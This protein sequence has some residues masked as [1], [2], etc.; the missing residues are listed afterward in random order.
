MCLLLYERKYVYR[1]TENW[2]SDK[3]RDHWQKSLFATSQQVAKISYP[4]WLPF[5]SHVCKVTGEACIHLKGFKQFRYTF[6]LNRQRLYGL[7]LGVQLLHCFLQFLSFR[8]CWWL[9][10]LLYVCCFRRAGSQYRAVTQ[11]T[12]LLPWKKLHGTAWRSHCCVGQALQQHNPV[13]KGN[14][15]WQLGPTALGK[16]RNDLV[17]FSICFL[18]LK[19]LNFPDL[20][21]LLV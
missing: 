6:V 19:K 7:L 14:L 16:L 13:A 3:T 18:V 11:R 12:S 17:S 20:K 1:K 10:W 9:P 2:R 21:S 4:C 8:Q 15:L 5:I